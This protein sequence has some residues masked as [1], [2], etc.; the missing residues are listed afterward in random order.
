MQLYKQ[1]TKYT[2]A[3]SSLAMVIHHFKPDF[4]LNIENEFDIWQHTATLPTKGSS[5][6]ALAV[7]A[8]K[9]GIQLKIVVGEP[10]YKFPGYK[11]KSYK[12]KEIEIANFSS[13]IFYNRAKELGIGIEE[14][15]FGLDEVRS[16]LEEGKVLLLRLIIGVVRNTK[17]NKR[18]PHYLPVFS[19]KEGK[20]LVMDPK[21]GPIELDEERMKEAFEKVAEIKRDHRMI[22]F[23]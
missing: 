8:K 7:Y 5:I 1:T 17:E 3:A 12:K 16:L 21:A 22:V 13:R 4:K 15:E 19:Y 10:E 2:C 6:Y 23:G 11:F 14:R 18:N 20:F 9:Q